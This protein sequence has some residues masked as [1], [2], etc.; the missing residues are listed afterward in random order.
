MIMSLSPDDELE[1]FD[2]DDQLPSPPPQYC[3]LP[4]PPRVT[5]TGSGGDKVDLSRLLAHSTPVASAKDRGG[6]KHSKKSLSSRKSRKRGLKPT[7]IVEESA[8][9]YSDDSSSSGDYRKIVIN[10]GSKNVR[11]Q[12]NF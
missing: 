12:G 7:N 3:D 8:S 6:A 11:K 4:P 10:L 2:L 5:T 9:C 1:E